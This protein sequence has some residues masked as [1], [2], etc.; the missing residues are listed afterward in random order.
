[1]RK[2]CKIKDYETL[3]RETKYLKCKITIIPKGDENDS[4][5]G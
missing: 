4:K 3:L 5:C 2:T 1:M